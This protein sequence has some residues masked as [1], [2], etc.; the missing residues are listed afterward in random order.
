MGLKEVLKWLEVKERKD[1]YTY[2]GTTKY[3]NHDIYPITPKE[4]TFGYLAY[5]AFWTNSGTAISTFTLGSAYIATGLNAG[6][7]IG[8]CLIG[9]IIASAIGFFGARPGQDYSIGYVRL[10]ALNSSGTKSLILI[11]YRLC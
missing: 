11:V 7:T 6:E 10:P 9:S 2:G 8:A 3:G 1:I 4:H 5:F